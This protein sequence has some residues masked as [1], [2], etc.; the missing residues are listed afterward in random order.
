VAQA[1]PADEQAN[2]N[3]SLM[4]VLPLALWHGGADAALVADAQRQSLATHGHVRSQVCCALYCLWAR[5]TLQE[6]P[7]P[8]HAALATLRAI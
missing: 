5:R 1:G 3:G 6:A 8:W 2:G 7:E 4:R